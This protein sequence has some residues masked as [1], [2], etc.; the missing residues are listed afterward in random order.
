MV[1]WLPGTVV[2]E[3]RPLLS[4]TRGGEPARSARGQLR[5]D[6]GGLA[7]CLPCLLE[8][9]S[10]SKPWEASRAP[11][12]TTQDNRRFSRFIRSAPAMVKP[13]Q[14]FDATDGAF[15]KGQKGAAEATQGT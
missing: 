8:P 7:A 1:R 15:Q 4:R 12:A 5:R 14:D 2:G 11:V 3:P 9:M 6:T 13:P 10:P